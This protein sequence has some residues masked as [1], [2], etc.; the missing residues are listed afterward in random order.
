L[1]A[2]ESIASVPGRRRRAIRRIFVVTAVALSSLAAVP[3]PAAAAVPYPEVPL[4]GWDTNGTVYAV[5]VVGDTVYLGGSFST[6]RSPGGGATMAR[7]NFAAIDAVTGEVLPF[8]ADT[9]DTVRAIES[10]GATVWVGGIFSNIGGV[11]RS[12]IAAVDAIS[13][14]VLGGFDVSVNGGVLGLALGGGRLY[15]SGRFTLIAGLPQDRMASLDPAT[16]VPDPAFQAGADAEVRDIAVSEVSG[17]L[18]A[19]GRFTTIGSQPW[20]YLAELDPDSGAG[21]GPG[22]S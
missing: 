16:G 6:L 14:A 3:G 12:N 8:A 1:V 2:R 21:I 5:K 15:A 13:G 20:A 18:F 7:S 10:D 9:N 22:F 4:D 17:R 19:G 11:G